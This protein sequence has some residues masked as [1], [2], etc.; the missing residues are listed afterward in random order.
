M[1]RVWPIFF[2][3]LLGL[4]RGGSA[5]PTTTGVVMS[6]KSCPD[7]NVTASLERHLAGGL[8]PHHQVAASVARVRARRALEE[9]R[10]LYTQTNFAGC[11]SLLSISEL[12]L[13]RSLAD[14]DPALQLRAHQLLAK[15]NLWLGICQWAAGEPHAAEQAFYRSAQLP[16]SP[17]PDPKL[18]PP[19]LIAAHRKAVA[20][21]REDVTCK[22]EAPLAAEHLQVDG[23]GPT[24]SG[25]NL[26]VA[27]GAHYLVIRVACAD[28]GD[29]QCTALQ[30][31]VGPGGLRSLRL[32]A[33][34]MRCRVQL[35]GVLVRSRITCINPREAQDPAFVAGVTKETRAG[36]TLVVDVAGDRLAMRMHTVGSE[37]FRHQLVSN[38]RP[39]ETLA[40][41]VLRSAVL[42]VGGNGSVVPQPPQ[43]PPP[44]NGPGKTKKTEWY[45][46]WWVWAIAA[47]TVAAIATT[48]AVVGSGSDE[49]TVVIGR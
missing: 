36:G 25:G 37:S 35:P 48:A 17:A 47:G 11:I 32:E 38:L 40:Q 29:T 49:V 4:P 19:G 44:T 46:K 41:L 43:P 10:R 33:S 24:V 26:K 16:L 23:R 31:L 21:P 8:A 3:L 15:V 39:D 45:K 2:L 18:L 7:T 22:L 28:R 30:H 6:G 1:R 20:Q 5:R 14:A 27:G 13:S 42:M 9:A 12:E 34:S